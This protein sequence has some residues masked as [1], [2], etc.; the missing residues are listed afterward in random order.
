MSNTPTWAKVL[1]FFVATALSA[2]TAYSG[3]QSRRTNEG[4]RSLEA[5][6]EARERRDANVAEFVGSFYALPCKQQMKL[7][8]FPLRRAA[9]LQRKVKRAEIEDYC[10]KVEG[11]EPTRILERQTVLGG[12]KARELRV[13]A[14]LRF[15]NDRQT[16][17]PGMRIAWVDLTLVRERATGSYK[18]TSLAEVQGAA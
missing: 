5:A 13:L 15:A 14:T 18:I 16:V 4:V 12:P 6:R 17:D 8:I 1:A 7:E 2:A 10:K 9:G 11:H 3:W